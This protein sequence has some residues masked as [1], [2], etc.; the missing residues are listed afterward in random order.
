[1]KSLSRDN[2]IRVLLFLV[3]V[4]STATAGGKDGLS[5][6]PADEI[7]IVRPEVDSEGKPTPVFVPGHQGQTLKFET[8]PTVLFHRYYYTGDRDFQGPMLPGGPSLIV[9]NDPRTGQQM[10]VEAMLL[11]GAPRIFYTKQGI[12]YVYKSKTISVSFGG[13]LCKEPSV[14]IRK[15]KHSSRIGSASQGAISRCKEFGDRTG[16][17]SAVNSIEAERKNAVMGIA[18]RMHDAGQFVV[19][20]VKW[21]WEATPL[22]SL[23]TPEPRPQRAL[24]QLSDG[25]TNELEG[26][27]ATIR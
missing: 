15:T 8:P 21:F 17:K 9:A 12:R 25:I 7:L 13:I 1:M 16:L 6:P 19:R 3:A 20:P 2:F 14:A 5:V 22:D 23:L 10:A 18:D 11:P 4:S 26:T 27:A 24:N